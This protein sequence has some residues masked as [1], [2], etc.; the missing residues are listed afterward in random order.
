L[1]ERSLEPTRNPSCR[2]ADGRQ[3]HLGGRRVRVASII[4]GWLAGL[5]VGCSVLVGAAIIGYLGWRRHVKSPLAL[6]RKTL[7]EDVQWVKERVA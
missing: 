5:T 4:P 7:R 1:H 3:S 6:T 2:G